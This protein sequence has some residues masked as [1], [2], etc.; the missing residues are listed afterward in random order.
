MR[1]HPGIVPGHRR[2]WHRERATSREPT[3]AGSASVTRADAMRQIAI[4]EVTLPM[5]ATTVVRRRS[6]RRTGART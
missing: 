3:E 1:R 6:K 4:G 2:V 5:C